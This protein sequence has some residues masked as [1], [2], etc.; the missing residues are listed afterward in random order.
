MTE[1]LPVRGPSNR[2]EEEQV[3]QVG[4]REMAREVD[5]T[6]Q[7]LKVFGCAEAALIRAPGG[8]SAVPG[9]PDGGLTTRLHLSGAHPLAFRYEGKR[10]R[11]Y[12]EPQGRVTV[13]VP[14]RAL[15]QA[16][17][18]PAED[19]HVLLLGEL[20]RAVGEEVGVNP[21]ALEFKPAFVVHDETMG[22]LLA[23]LA[24]EV[25]GRNPGG[26]LFAEGLA[27]ALAVHL[28][29]TYSSLGE[30]ARRELTPGPGAALSPK[31]VRRALDYIG[32]NLLSDL[33]LADLARAADLSERQLYRLFRGAVGLSPHQYVIQERVERAKGL[34]RRT[35]LSVAAVA[36]AVGFAHRQHLDRHFKRL[37]GVSPERYRQEAMR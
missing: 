18:V 15:E 34:L 14:G 29:R 10:W 3:R 5:W 13:A 1:N 21:R 7:N 31:A 25:A 20:L 30:G 35:D 32:D 24:D 6:V 16:S 28:L 23:A 36:V 26:R 9:V 33:S 19:L 17:P 2:P 22:L 37:T 12:A 4:L 11:E 8:Q 27:N